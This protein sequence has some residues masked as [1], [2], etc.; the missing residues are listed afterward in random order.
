MK[1]PI[2]K[3]WDCVGDECRLFNQATGECILYRIFRESL[4]ES[5]E[6]E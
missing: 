5:E 2:L 6:E 3:G 1:C 4:K